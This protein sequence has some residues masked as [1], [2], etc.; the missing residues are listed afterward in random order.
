MSPN[1]WNEDPSPKGRK[2]QHT[3][4]RALSPYTKGAEQSPSINS[5]L[6]D[7]DLV[8]LNFYKITRHHADRKITEFF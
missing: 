3:T 4:Q 2:L 5:R 1:R 8:I 6:H 7:G